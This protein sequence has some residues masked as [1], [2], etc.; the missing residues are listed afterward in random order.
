MKMKKLLIAITVFLTCG[1]SISAQTK[2]FKWDSELCQHEGTYDSKKYTEAELKN[3]QELQSMI[4]SI[5]IF[6]DPTANEYK[7]IAK[8]SLEDLAKEYAEQSAKLKNL[9]IVK[10][11]YWEH[12]RDRKI[13][14]LDSY[15]ELSKITMQ[16]YNNPS[17][18]KDFTQGDICVGFYAEP[19]IAGGEYLY[20]TWQKVNMD[21]RS[22]NSSPARLKGIFDQQNA[23]PDRLKY[24]R[25][26]VMRYGW[27]NCAIQEIPRVEHDESTTEEF[28]KLFINV[29][30][31]CDE[32][33]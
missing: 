26:E 24:A 29:K 22:K 27:W 4:G 14:E 15:Y 19:L 31:E 32:P 3:T 5:P 6:T 18:L 17:I 1:I 28:N 30:E 16:A 9:T 11:D 8:L 21:S 2:V 12:I 23:S 25:V 33:E 20:V 13:A 7:D 10:S